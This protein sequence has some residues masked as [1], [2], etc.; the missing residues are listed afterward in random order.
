M[1]APRCLLTLIWALQVVHS[2]REPQWMGSIL[3]PT[4]GT[5]SPV[6]LLDS[7]YAN[8]TCSEVPNKLV[9][10]DGGTRCTRFPSTL[11]TTV[12]VVQVQNTA[13]ITI[14]SG[15]LSNFTHLEELEI[16]HNSRL[17]SIEPGTFQGMS[18]LRNLSIS[19]NE[20]LTH[21]EAGVFDGLNNLR[22]LRMKKGGFFH[23]GM[24]APALTPVSLPNLQKLVLDENPFQKIAASDLVPMNGS[25]LQQLHLIACQLDFIHP[26]A[27]VPLR[28][29]RALLLGQNTLNSSTITALVSHL[30]GEGVPLYLLS[31]YGMGFLKRPPMNVME[32][33]AD[34]NITHLVLARN[35]FQK[36]K[37]GSFPTMPRLQYL[38]LREIVATDLKP[39]T[40]SPGVMPQLRTLLFGG[41]MLPGVIPGV[42]VPQL[43]SL[44]LSA[45][46]GDPRTRSYFDVGEGSFVNMTNLSFLNLSYN[47]LRKVTKET[48]IGL[49]NLD[50]HLGLKNASIYQLEEGAFENLRKLQFL[51][52]E[53]NPFPKFYKLSA[54]MFKGLNELRVLL[55]SGC[56][57]TFLTS[58]IFRN[59]PNLQYLSLRENQLTT[60][61]PQLFAAL[62]HLR[63]IDLSDNQL[64]FAKNSSQR[65]FGNNTELE[66]IFLSRNKLTY[67]N[68]T[69]LADAES[70]KRLELYDNNLLCQCA[71]FM[72][73]K[74][75]LMDRNL[76]LEDM[77]IAG[78]STLRCFS[79]DEW[80]NRLV[81][82]YI[83]S[84]GE[85]CVEP[86][87]ESRLMIWTM[88]L[89]I[90]VV[91]TCFVTAAVAY[92]YRAH[93]RYWM[94]LARMDLKRRGLKRI[95]KKACEGYNNFQYDAFV[96]YSNE[97]RN[98]VVRLVAMLENYEPFLR[99]CV[100]ERDFEIGSVI[101]ESVLQS[102]ALSRRTLLIVSDAFAR[103]QWCR[104]ELQL[105]E[106]HRLFLS[107]E[108][109]ET[110]DPLIIIKLG[111]IARPHLTPT[112]KYLLRTRIYLEWNSEPR[113]QRQFW[114]RLRTALAPPSITI[115]PTENQS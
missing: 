98:F 34:S 29:L 13:I 32:A 85:D 55:L 95:S 20:N 70:L 94:F 60:L 88:V 65:V 86:A 47:N 61:S 23:M 82:D 51:N 54:A 114:D 104:W 31:L 101:S 103:S 56:G 33:V 102:V 58:D 72:S 62:P 69:M 84:L 52:L 12:P 39:G 21:L 92:H 36:L 67:L 28:H 30:A 75:W 109:Q 35:Q 77:H 43:E 45:N 6:P 111:E 17:Q 50:K 41:N 26:D 15:D 64:E 22:E 37:P 83:N 57:I 99:L 3:V 59:L 106:N 97:D 107:D 7:E 14:R 76:T 42:L 27:L 53:Y 1:L 49:E 18:S 63:G 78:L 73:T 81:I 46:F 4:D 80:M 91:V 108:I 5:S 113:K 71:P 105:A 11:N 93:I 79:P 87:A 115:T 90:L 66:V 16:D 8:C 89:L 38:D 9:I 110:G 10:C 24:I 68:P 96:S 48:F 2:Q 74:K 19:Y 100:Y 40:L 44:D 25:S 112:L